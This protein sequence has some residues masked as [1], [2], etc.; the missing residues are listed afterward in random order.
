M[1]SIYA[2]ISQMMTTKWRSHYQ[3]RNCSVLHQILIRSVAYFANILNKRYSTK[4]LKDRELVQTQN[5]FY[6]L[7]S[8]NR[9]FESCFPGQGR[10]AAIACMR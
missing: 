3:R 9:N 10:M 4:Y 1:V 2:N 5:T 6:T 7:G 8:L